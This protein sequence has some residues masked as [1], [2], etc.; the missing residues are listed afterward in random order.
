[1]LRSFEN[2]RVRQGKYPM[3]LDSKPWFCH[4][5]GI[6][7][8]YVYSKLFV[9]EGSWQGGSSCHPRLEQGSSGHRDS[10]SPGHQ[11]PLG[12]KALCRSVGR[13]WRLRHLQHDGHGQGQAPWHSLSLEQL[14]GLEDDPGNHIPKVL[15]Q[16][17]PSITR[18]VTGRKRCEWIC[19]YTPCLSAYNSY[20]QHSYMC[21]DVH[22]HTATWISCYTLMI[23]C[24]ADA[25]YC[26]KSSLQG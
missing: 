10:P 15:L 6:S 12:D 7:H 5:V 21:L 22:L 19:M 24:L 23:L 20:K 9:R 3:G 13:R 17:L 25:V 18:K 4:Y 1:M 26:W 16:L 2:C 8:K 14:P 11:A